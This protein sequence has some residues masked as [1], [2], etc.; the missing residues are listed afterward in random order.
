[1]EFNWKERTLAPLDTRYV[2]QTIDALICIALLIPSL[3]LAKK[4]LSDGLVTQV[5]EFIS[6]CGLHLQRKRIQLQTL[7]KKCR[8]FF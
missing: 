5:S 6:P 1:M 2:S 8:N 3:L 7:H 4:F